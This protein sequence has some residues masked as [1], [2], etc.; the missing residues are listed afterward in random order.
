[1]FVNDAGICKKTKGDWKTFLQS[2]SQLC[3]G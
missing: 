3:D 1:M 2:C